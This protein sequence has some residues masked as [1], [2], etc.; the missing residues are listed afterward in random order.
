MSSLPFYQSHAPRIVTG[1]YTRLAPPGYAFIVDAN[2]NYV[3][4]EAG[5]RLIAPLG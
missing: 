5:N 3:T 2:N 1:R 4:D